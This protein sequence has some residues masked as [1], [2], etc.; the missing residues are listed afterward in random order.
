MRAKLVLL[1]VSFIAALGS[2]AICLAD[3]AESARKVI[4]ANK[5]A[6]VTV[7]LV[8]EAKMPHG[9]ESNKEEK[10]VS[11]TGTVVDPSGLVVSELSQVDPEV[12]LS[13]ISGGKNE[14]GLQVRVVDA[15]IKA[16]DGTEIP[17]DVVLRDRDLD[18]VFLRPKKPLQAPMKYV[19]L[20]QS[21]EP[22]VMD[23]V[24]FLWRL[25]QV[26]N[27]VL[28]GELLR[29]EAV[30]TKP[31]LSYAIDA[32]KL[33]CP[34]FTIDGKPV[35][36]VI[37]RFSQASRGTNLFGGTDEVVAMIL[38]CSSVLKAARQALQAQP[39]RAVY[40]PAKKPDKL[41]PKTP[42]K[43]PVPKK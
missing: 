20:S 42:A 36:I 23:E 39:E 41:N 29:V 14:E 40:G 8:L 15:K 21:G 5:E 33:G 28:A 37:L 12:I 35:G 7:Q 22:Q 6:V 13:V 30:V 16:D 32:P 25:G 31:Q 1:A 34:V 10:R 9:G 27:R 24:V 18:L 4:E 26:A 19:D 2:Y 3:A 11:I 43:P 17:A 38:P